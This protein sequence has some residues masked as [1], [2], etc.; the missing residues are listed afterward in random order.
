MIQYV[1]LLRG[2]NSGQ[3]PSQKMD[4]LQ[5]I[6]E[7]LGLQD[8]KTVMASGNVLF[9]TD[10]KDHKILEKTNRKSLKKRTGI[11]TATIIRTKKEIKKLVD[12][13][14]FRNIKVSSE[15]KPNVTFIKESSEKNGKFP[16]TGKGYTILGNYE[17][18]IFSV[19]DL[20]TT[21]TPK[22]MNDLEKKFGK[23]ITTRS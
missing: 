17:G 2:I 16:L 20:K 12:L 18:T 7:E 23:N 3:N 21:R 10:T 14:P 5:K 22:L 1:E 11:K 13:N 4:K 6:F 19:I 8:V 9:K 15:K